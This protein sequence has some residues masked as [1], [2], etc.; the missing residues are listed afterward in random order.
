MIR[1]SET[2]KMKKNAVKPRAYSVC[3][4]VAM[5]CIILMTPILSSAE[6]GSVT[7][8]AKTSFQVGDTMDVT[9]KYAASSL[10]RI[11][12]Q[13]I[14][15]PDLLQYISGGT[16]GSAAGIVQMSRGMDGQ[17]SQSFT[18]HFKALIAG[19][20]Y[21][22]VQ[23]LELVDLDERDL[24]NPGASVKYTIKE[25]PTEDNG[26]ST[27]TPD[28]SSSKTSDSVDNNN[29]SVDE[30]T[31]NKAPDTIWIYAGAIAVTSILLILA[32]VIS[33][34]KRK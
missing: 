3:I 19:A 12:G 21:L 14:Y 4:L 30:S 16:S 28:D 2:N 6:T 33:R 31:T 26:D 29:G 5:L 20:D 24:G 23:T 13:L 1:T 17:S 11:N 9:V 10:G 32:I 22:Q 25:V 8:A 27:I 7:I 34:Q 15:D 18:I